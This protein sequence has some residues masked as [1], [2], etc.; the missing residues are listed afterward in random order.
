MKQKTFYHIILDQ[1]G[2]MQDCLIP[3]LSGY[4]EQLQVIRSLQQRFPEQEIRLGLTRFNQEVMHSYFA[5]HPDRVTELNQAIYRP[6][7][8][9]AL[10]DAIGQTVRKLQEQILSERIAG[11]A[12][13]VVVIITD[14]YENASRRYS[15]TQIKG[16]IKELESTG[17]WTFSYLGATLDA[18]QIATALN[19]QQQNSMCFEKASIMGA[20]DLLGASMDGFL[21]K[22]STGKNTSGFLKP[23]D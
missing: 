14:G 2:S 20:F 10:Y 8:C 19:I 6:D 13:V 3:T 17:T 15:A 18:V 1:S 7:G 16:L 22:R 12:A 21:E 23:R 4:N 5:Q 9:T 11:M